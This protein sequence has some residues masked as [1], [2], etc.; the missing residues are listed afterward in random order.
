MFPLPS[1]ILP[2]VSDHLVQICVRPH[3]NSL[4]NVLEVS[5]VFPNHVD[6]CILIIKSSV[7]VP[8]DSVRHV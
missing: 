6:P 5:T 8:L 7:K 2:A 1:S 3:L 4:Q